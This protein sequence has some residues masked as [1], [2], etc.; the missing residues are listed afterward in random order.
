M[1]Y[2]IFQHPCHNLATKL[3]YEVSVSLTLNPWMALMRKIQYSFSQAKR[4]LEG[5]EFLVVLVF[6]DT[7]SSLLTIK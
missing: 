7:E 4:D 1:T 6:H 2:R 3:L 5:S